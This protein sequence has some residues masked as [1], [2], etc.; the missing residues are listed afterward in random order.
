MKNIR[1]KFLTTGK[2]EGW[3]Y[4]ILLFIAMPLK[5]IFDMPLAV[6]I[7]GSAHGLLFVAYVILLG[8]AHF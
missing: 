1:E 6:R 4:L 2:I 8:L 5:Y 3:S 7:V